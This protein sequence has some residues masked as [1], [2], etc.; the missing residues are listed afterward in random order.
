VAKAK[1]TTIIEFT[2]KIASV[3]IAYRQ[4]IQSKF[5]EHD[6]DL[7]F[8]MLQVL[9]C[10]WNQDGINQQ[11]IANLTVKDK[12]SMT[13]LIDNLTKRDLVY[14][15]EDENDRRNKLVH[16]TPKGKTTKAEVQPFID[17]MYAAAGKGL[18][19]NELERCMSLLQ[20]LEQNLKEHI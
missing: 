16:L 6:V 3:N 9:A 4:F 15:Q 13:Y 17:E 12:A 14:R 20:K 2:R 19:I 5:K 8:E 7:T 11:E 18:D 1:H 10:L